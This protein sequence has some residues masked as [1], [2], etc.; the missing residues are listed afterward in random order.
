MNLGMSGT[1]YSYFSTLGSVQELINS[2]LVV[3]DAR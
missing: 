2:N 1:V 3:L